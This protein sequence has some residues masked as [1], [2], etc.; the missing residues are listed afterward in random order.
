MNRPPEA[1]YHTATDPYELRNL[2]DNAS[3]Q[4][5]LNTLSR[6]LDRWMESQGDP[7]VEQDTQQSQQAAKRGQHRFRA[8][9]VTP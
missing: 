9:S 4:K 6:E 1:L 8:P 7:G 3:A 5:T 2:V